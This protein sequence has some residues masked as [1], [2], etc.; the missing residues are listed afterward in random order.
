[1]RD[2][3][4][5]GFKGGLVKYNKQFQ[6]V[7]ALFTKFEVYC[8]MPLDENN[9]LIG[10]FSNRLEILNSLDMQMSTTFEL[11]RNTYEKLL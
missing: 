9:V 1:M 5:F 11:K 10:K 7:L 2:C 6:V 4:I 3:Y 8:L